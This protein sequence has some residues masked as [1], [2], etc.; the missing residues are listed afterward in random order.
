MTA[1][2]TGDTK[3]VFPPKVAHW[4]EEWQ[5]MKG[6]KWQKFTLS[7]QPCSAL[8]LTLPC[9]IFLILDLLSKDYVYVLTSRL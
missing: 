4:F 6:C 1:A 9:T 2:A 8:V 3:F 5:A 7:K